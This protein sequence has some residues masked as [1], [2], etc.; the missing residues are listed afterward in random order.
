M[1]LMAG[2]TTWH[3]SCGAGRA[4]EDV[5]GPGHVHAAPVR[6]H[7]FVSVHQCLQAGQS[8]NASSGSN[9][10]LLLLQHISTLSLLT[11]FARGAGSEAVQHAHL[12]SRSTHAHHPA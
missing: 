12:L 4:P 7:T 1:T 3:A 10:M 8:S 6:V 5:S 9:G 11:G 2:T